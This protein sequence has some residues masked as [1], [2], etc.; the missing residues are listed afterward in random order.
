M[1]G[2]GSRFDGILGGVSMEQ[3]AYGIVY[4]EKFVDRD[5][6]V[7]AGI[8]AGQASLGRVVGEGVGVG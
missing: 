2:K 8:A 7:E 4:N 3:V 1:V 6:A 5:P